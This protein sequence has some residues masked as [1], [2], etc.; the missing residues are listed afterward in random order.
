MP[1]FLQSARHGFVCCE[2]ADEAVAAD[3][4]ALRRAPASGPERARTLHNLAISLY[5]RYRCSSDGRDVNAAIVHQR[6]VLRLLPPRHPDRTT[7]EGN[8]AMFLAGRR[9][10]GDL[11]EAS[12]LARHALAKTPA[13]S[14]GYAENLAQAAQIEFE[15]FKSSNDL[16]RLDTAVEMLT[17]LVRERPLSRDGAIEPH[18]NYAVA[19]LTRYGTDRSRIAD[20]DAA[21]STLTDLR[22]ADLTGSP[23]GTANIVRAHLIQALNARYDLTGDRAG[24]AQIAELHEELSKSGDQALAGQTRLLA[25]DNAA[26][27]SIA[28]YLRTGDLAELGRAVREQEEALLA[29]RHGDPSRAGLLG[30]LGLCKLLRHRARYGQD[31]PSSDDLVDGMRLAEEAVATGGE[32]VYEAA[33]AAILGTLIVQESAH[34]GRPR[35]ARIDLAN[36]LLSWALGTMSPADPQRVALVSQLSQGLALRSMLDGDVAGLRRAI[37]ELDA[38]CATLQPR[39]P[40]S[41]G[42]RN[43]LAGLL[44]T[45]AVRT[46]GADGSLDR[47][48]S[49]ARRAV[50]DGLDQHPAGAFQT[51]RQWGDAC[52]QLGR[53]DLAGEGYAAAL[54]ILH[55]L[56]RAQLTMADKDVGLGQARNVTARATVA[57]AYAGHPDEA[58]LAVETGR[59]VAL[60]EALGMEQA[61]ILD[62]AASSHSGLVHAYQRAARELAQLQRGQPGTDSLGGLMASSPGPDRQARLRAARAALDAA[63]GDLELALGVEL[64]RAPS[65]GSFRA[66]VTAAGLPVVYVV[67]SEI[68]GAAVIAGAGASVRVV[69]LPALTDSKVEEMTQLW[70]RAVAEDDLAA[71]D[72]ATAL[73]WSDVMA[74]ITRAL[75]SYPRAV[76]VPVGGLGILPLHTAGWQEPDHEWRFAGDHVSYGYAPNARVLAVC[77]QRARRQQG[78]SALLVADPRTDAKAD[79]LPAAI[80][81]CEEIRRHFAGADLLACLYGEE[82]TAEQVLGWLP[83]ASIMHFACHAAVDRI[84]VLDSALILAGTGRLTLRD[85]LMA[86][87]PDARLAVL[88]ACSTALIGAE[89]QDEVVS[90]PAA[91]AQAG[92][93]G[94]VGS[95]WEVDDAASA[96]LLA[97]FYDLW[98]A[99]GLPGATALAGAQ[100][101]LREATNGEIAERYPAIDLAA[102]SDSGRLQQWRGQRDFASPLWW[103]PFIFVGA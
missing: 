69:R 55:D 87:L 48:A 100:R 31:G 52:W 94:V 38:A 28:A 93:A 82:A 102:P 3:V 83:R 78:R 65:P 42:A 62:V 6:A 7:S 101:W 72:R 41:S 29:T 53:L 8:L 88:S 84:N 74:E 90:L 12:V 4:S 51:A 2:E 54:R 39:S 96:V 73:M 95:L 56:T 68:G 80:Q 77:T 66:T 9:A 15:F 67:A 16:A 58:A 70:L 99:E 92:V 79:P 21:L 61:R 17:E 20:L 32:G 33:S 37:D 75:H 14:P 45:L 43:A 91:L 36:G 57:L 13:D 47:A 19:C 76:L 24:R 10:P 30:N 89:L 27:V 59:A 50:A 40:Y 35:A 34:A 63:V 49:A 1:P 81:E 11:A 97:R 23:P 26:T 60:S 22:A 46:G 44:L 18:V 25:H 64:L 98:L 71:A 85:V 103:A 86:Q 5:S